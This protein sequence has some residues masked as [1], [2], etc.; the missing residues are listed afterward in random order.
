LHNERNERFDENVAAFSEVAP[1][2]EK[3]DELLA[4]VAFAVVVFEEFK[5]LWGY[6]RG[7]LSDKL[8]V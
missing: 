5:E 4:K 3:I 2:L 8:L 6:H 7:S 1:L